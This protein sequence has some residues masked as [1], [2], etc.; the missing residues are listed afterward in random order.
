MTPLD[1]ELTDDQE[2]LLKLIHGVFE[3]DAGWPVWDYIDRSIKPRGTAEK[4]LRSLPQV[5]GIGGIRYGLVSWESSGLQVPRPDTTI[6]LTVAGVLRV[7]PAS[8]L[9][10]LW[11][12][13]FCYLRSAQAA[14]KPSP[15]DVLTLEVSDDQVIAHLFPDRARRGDTALVGRRMAQLRLLLEQQPFLWRS[16]IV[17]PHPPDG[18][19]TIRVPADIVRFE[20]ADT[21]GAY[22]ERLIELVAPEPVDPEAESRSQLG[23]EDE[24]ATNTSSRSTTFA[25]MTSESHPDPKAVF[26]VHGRNEVARKGMFDFLRSIGLKP[27]EWSQAVKLTGKAAPYIGEVL[28]AAFTAARA[29]VVLMT[30]DEITY[31]RR[32][33]TS[34]DDDPDYQPSSQARPN[35]LF[36]AG[37]AMGRDPDRTVLVELGKVRPFS[38]VGGRHAVHMD[39]GV[40][41]RKDLAQRLETAGCDVDLSGSDWITAGD[42]TPPPPPGDGLPLGRKLPAGSPSTAIRVEAKYLDRGSASGRLHLTNYSTF[43]IHDLDFDLPEEAG[44]NFTVHREGLP[45]RKLPPGKTVSFIT[46]RTMG[47]G[48]SHFEIAITGKTPEGEPFSIEDFVSLV[49][50]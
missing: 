5:G 9:L 23:V 27:L 46:S 19:W 44:P 17:Q 39:N 21:V 4:A 33:Y 40:E 22:I 8:P 50:C 43:P 35:V 34:G 32:E 20:R 14:L 37:M 10:D 41:G 1:I 30:P 31:L 7:E 47:S 29:V 49:G 15:T 3:A 48:A 6:A 26:V 25:L 28:D 11:M 36:E 16:C 24:Y 2:Q 12:R 13:L 38:D 18:P 45:V 42:L